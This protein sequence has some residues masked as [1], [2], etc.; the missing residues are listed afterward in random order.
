MVEYVFGC[1]GSSARQPARRLG[2]ENARM[3]FPVFV[4]GCVDDLF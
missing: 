2:L 3:S 1:L 4:V